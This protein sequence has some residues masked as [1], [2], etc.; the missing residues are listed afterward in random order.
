MQRVAE[1]VRRLRAVGCAVWV[2]QHPHPETHVVAEAAELA[3]PPL[4]HGAFLRLLE[5]VDVVWTD[6]GGVQEECVALGRKAWVLREETERPEGVRSGHLELMGTEVAT[7]VNCGLHARQGPVPAASPY[8]TGDAGR[9][10]A[11]V[12]A[13]AWS[14]GTAT[15]RT[16][17]GS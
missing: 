5:A 4:G 13:K 10:I 6:S 11:D 3:I 12:L 17:P 2:M 1:A 14:A 16:V 7:L 8:G 15:P 9:R